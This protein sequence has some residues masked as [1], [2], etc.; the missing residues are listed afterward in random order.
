MRAWN[1]VGSPSQ[2]DKFQLTERACSQRLTELSVSE[3]ASTVFVQPQWAK[4]WGGDQNWE[5]AA[6]KT[7][8]NLPAPL[9]TCPCSACHAMLSG[10]GTSSRHQQS[11]PAVKAW[12][13]TAHSVDT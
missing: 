8:P 9:C 1:I 4:L 2:P 10:G 5:K 7:G 12:R 3:E 13:K 6:T 11:A